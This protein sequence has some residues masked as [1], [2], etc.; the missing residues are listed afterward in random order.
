MSDRQHPEAH[1]VQYQYSPQTSAQSH[2]PQQGQSA[3]PQAPPYYYAQYPNYY[4]PQGTQQQEQQQSGDVHAAAAANYMGHVMPTMYPSVYPQAQAVQHAQQ[5]Q[6]QQQQQPQQQDPQQPYQY[7]YRNDYVLMMPQQGG[8][9]QMQAQS[10]PPSTQMMATP[11]VTD[12]TGQIAPPG[13][14]PKVSTTLWEDEGT[15]CFQVEARGICVARREDNDMI[16][17][18]KLLNVAGMTR[19]RRDGLLKGERNRHVVKAGAM[20]L[21]GVWI[22]YDRALDFANKEKIIDLLYPL[23]VTDIKSVLY[24][25]NQSREAGQPAQSQVQQETQAQPSQQQPNTGQNTPKL[26]QPPSQTSPRTAE[27]K[28][29]YPQ[30]QAQAAPGNQQQQQYYYPGQDSAYRY[31]QQNQQYYSEQVNDD[32]SYDEPKTEA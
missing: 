17:G 23:F 3:S 11:T 7:Q 25:P 26:S 16:N 30:Q 31:G 10:Q 5:Q 18:T 21:K 14:K 24:H 8:V 9:Q 22:P 13:V 6:Q 20:H 32:R 19:G 2:Q 12:P 27:K 29:Y 1:P 28:E 15:L 4:Y